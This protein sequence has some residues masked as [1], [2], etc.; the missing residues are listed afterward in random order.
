MREV[1]IVGHE[2]EE[3]LVKPFAFVS[4]KDGASGSDALAAELKKWLQG[5]LAPHK[6]PRWFEWR[7]TLPRNDRGKVA[8]KALK[9]E[10]SAKRTN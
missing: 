5:K 9:D 10:L 7:D 1:C 4:L 2:D 6:Y 8:R 3:G